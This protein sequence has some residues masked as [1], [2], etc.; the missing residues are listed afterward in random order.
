[1]N[2]ETKYVISGKALD[3]EG[4]IVDKKLEFSSSVPEDSVSGM[5]LPITKAVAKKLIRDYTLAQQRLF[6]YLNQNEKISPDLKELAKLVDPNNQV[7]SGIYGKQAIMHILNSPKCEGIRYTLCRYNDE[8]SIILQGVN[9]DGKPLSADNT[10]LF[11][12][13][14]DNDDPQYEIKGS[15][16]TISEIEKLIA[17]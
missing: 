7:I 10:K 2:K 13:D 17:D 9:A 1:M 4:N 6:N 12:G 11:S 16:L 15:G 8:A 14:D 3:K 5:G